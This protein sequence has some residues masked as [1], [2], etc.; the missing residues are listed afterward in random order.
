MR[1]LSSPLS[2]SLTFINHP[3]LYGSLFTYSIILNQYHVMISR[4]IHHVEV[5]AMY[6]IQDFVKQSAGSCTYINIIL[7]DIVL[8]LNSR[9]D[10]SNDTLNTQVE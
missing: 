3:P 9:P 2:D 6:N 10:A 1:S 8:L 4:F 7:Q 5:V